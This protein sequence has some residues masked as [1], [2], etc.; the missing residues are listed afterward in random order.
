V[1]YFEFA[2]GLIVLDLIVSALGF[3]FL[4]AF[5]VSRKAKAAHLAALKNLGVETKEEI[6]SLKK[7]SD[8]LRDN[9]E[10]P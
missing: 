6:A 5:W 10:Q 2:G 4:R 7:L 8:L 9:E 3:L 1:P